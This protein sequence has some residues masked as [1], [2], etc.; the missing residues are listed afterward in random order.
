MIAPPGTWPIDAERSRVE[1]AIKHMLLATLRGRFESFHGV[2]QVA[3]DGLAQASG[4]VDAASICTHDAVRDGH[5]RSSSD[6]FDVG[7]YPQI[8]FSSSRIEELPG[9]RVRILGD[10]TMRGVTREIELSGQARE[11]EPRGADPELALALHGELNRREFGLIWN[12]T[13]D[14]G[15]AL[16]GNT[17][18]IA[19]ELAAVRAAGAADQ[20]ARR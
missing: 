12:Q 9:G 6:F 19:V 13:L 10:L 7:R 15:G 3:E 5:L 4:S 11:R 2:L 20:P 18:K 8:G 16:I 14:S 17:V 1:F